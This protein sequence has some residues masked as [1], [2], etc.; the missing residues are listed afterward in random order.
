MVVLLS[1][2][3]PSLRRP[4]P[5]EFGEINVL[6]TTDVHGWYS[7]NRRVPANPADLGDLSSLV[8]WL[9]KE[10][11]TK[12]GDVFLAD[13]GD[14]VDGAGLADITT[15]SGELLW[16]LLVEMGDYNIIGTGNHELYLNRTVEGMKPALFD[17]CGSSCLTSNII[18][19][20]GKEPLG[21][22]YNV[23]KGTNTGKRV[24][25]M[26]FMYDMGDVACEAV[27]VIDVAIALK[28]PWF[29]EAMAEDFE[30]VIATV[31][32]DLNEPNVDA[33]L[34]AIREHHPTVPVIFPSGHSHRQGFSRKDDHAASIQAGANFELE[35]ASFTPGDSR[36]RF[37][38]RYIQPSVEE[39]R[40]VSGKSEHEFVTPK[41]RLLK[42]K[43][44][45]ARKKY[46]L[47]EIVGCATK[48]YDRGAPTDSTDSI[49]GVYFREVLPFALYDTGKSDNTPLL[50]ESTG[51]YRDN[52][53]AGEIQVDDVFIMSPF[54]VSGFPM[55]QLIQFY[56]FTDLCLSL[57]ALGSNHQNYYLYF[58]NIDGADILAVLQS[59][60]ARV[61]RADNP[62]VQHYPSAE[63][64]RHDI[65]NLPSWAASIEPVPGTTYDLLCTNHNVERCQQALLSVTGR[66]LEAKRYTTRGEE[67][68]NSDLWFHFIREKW[69]C[70]NHAESS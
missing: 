63:G 16:P 50:I 49:W 28:E 70:D 11:A 6:Y 52:L 69:Q 33:I 36:T 42:E 40:R 62:E 38:Y 24:L 41:G 18:W 39:F 21:K 46:G 25:G 44:A 32:M 35:F 57:S 23:M 13:T 26:S 10:A 51:T 68:D 58:E 56:T 65:A 27:N 64:I 67:L 12:G 20:E 60:G 34:A 55:C 22:R 19:A 48:D 30:A 54:K 37:D 9:K 31:H 66:D 43:I 1:S 45:A 17:K 61:R 2:A 14:Y 29:A 15:P 5:L 59:V 3:S 4:S 47:D 7:G 53:R 8:H